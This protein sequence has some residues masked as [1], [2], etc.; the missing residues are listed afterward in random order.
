MKRIIL[1]ISLAIITGNIFGQAKKPTIMVVPS[2]VWCNKNGFTTTYENQGSKVMIPDYKIAMQSDENLILVIAKI[3]TLMSDRGFP[4]K[5]LESVLKNVEQQAAQDNMRTSKEGSSLAESPLDVLKKTAKA[6]IIMQ[7]TYTL[8]QTG[9]KKSV[10]FNLQGIDAYTG[11]QIAGAQGTGAP[12]FSS[13]LPVLLEEAVLSQL[14]NFNAQLQTHFDD[15][16]ANG[17]EVTV[18]IQ[19]WDNG[20]GTDL[21][22][23]YDGDELGEIID[24]WFFKN[25][26]NGR[27]SKSESSESYMFFEQVRI[28][29]YD[30]NN[31]PMDTKDFVQQLRK[32][33]KEPPYNLICKADM[34]GLGAGLLYIGEK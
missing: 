8:N 34:N 27:Y 5:N 17:R 3:N 16:L 13:E 2:D 11:K 30:A 14:D 29:L 26:V 4:L 32:F 18:R 6:D 28:P 10:T 7:L 25:S 22:S 1:L 15:L 24:D 19:V 21:E 33:L 31:K 20:S 12:S 9:P 23:E